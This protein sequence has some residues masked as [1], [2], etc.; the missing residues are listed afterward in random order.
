MNR[1]TN[2]RLGIETHRG[3]FAL[4]YRHNADIT[5]T[6]QA[7]QNDHPQTNSVLSIYSCR[8]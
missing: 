2:G 6:E 1:Y 5:D 8:K 4:T 7:M 3:T